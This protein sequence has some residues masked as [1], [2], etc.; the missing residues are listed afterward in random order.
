MA[1]LYCGKEIGPIR[2]LRDPEF[3]TP[4]HRKQYKDR[5]RKVLLQ[6]SSTESTPTRMASFIEASRGWSGNP[7]SVLVAAGF[8]SVHTI[9]ISRAWPV[10]IPGV[11]SQRFASL[12]PKY[13]NTADPAIRSVPAAFRWSSGLPEFTLRPAEWQPPAVEAEAVPPKLC[14]RWM[15]APKAVAAERELQPNLAPA[16][17]AS[18]SLCL[19][20]HLELA[21]AEECEPD[22]PAAA[23]PPPCVH[24]MPGL[25]ALP[26]ARMVHS[27][28]AEALP[29][30]ETRGALLPGREFFERSL[31]SAICPPEPLVPSPPAQPVVREVAA[32][33]ALL[34]VTRIEC[35]LP[36]LPAASAHS[37]C[38]NSGVDLLCPI[39]SSEPVMSEI[40]MRFCSAPLAFGTS[41]PQF[42][43]FAIQPAGETSA[44]A[45]P[46]HPG[47]APSLTPLPAE[48]PHS[49]A[50]DLF[51][52]LPVAPALHLGL[53]ESGGRL[54][55]AACAPAAFEQASGVA[56]APQPVANRNAAVLQ[57]LASLRTALPENDRP[58]PEPQI[59]ESQLIP[60][61]YHCI[62][63][64]G[65]PRPDWHW[66]TE[67]AG[68]R[69]LPFA[70]RPVFDRVETRR[71]PRTAPAPAEII[72][73]PEGGRVRRRSFVE[74]AQKAI[75][76]SVLVTIGLWCGSRAA[77]LSRMV[78]N[79]DA[80]LEVGVGRLAPGVAASGQPRTAARVT[81]AAWVRDSIA[82][83]AASEVTDSF[84]G[85]MAAWGTVG[86]SWAP[87]WSRHRDGYV[88]PG[89]LALFGPTLNYTD[90][91]LEFFGEIENKGMGWV[92]R[93]RDQQNFYA[94]KF[95]VLEPG[96][97]PVLAI[98]HYPVVGGKPG[99][100]TEVPLSIMVHN[101]TAY[102]VAVRVRGNRFTTAIEGQDV[103]SWTD[104][105]LAAGGVGFFIEAGERARLYWM[106]VSKNDDLLGRICAILSGNSVEESQTARLERAWPQRSLPERMPAPP[107][108]GG[109]DGALL[110]AE[111]NEVAFT[112]SLRAR[113]ANQKRIRLWSL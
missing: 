24:W 11:Q 64:R 2:L 105:A 25:A 86:N 47:I 10:S 84:K 92:V 38:A 52:S 12:G 14:D 78:V 55:E 111:T 85:G 48:M 97:R 17:S 36:S 82:R 42:V 72:P 35:R 66:L 6:E 60:L 29:I 80:S 87:G 104:D 59:P 67:M 57:P 8:E 83:R 99:R 34:P 109:P 1:C 113:A 61:E 50:G 7:A 56:S 16:I 106:K 3:C 62:R 79:H 101:R 23:P 88:Q 30:G 90:Y 93:A 13:R 33:A 74:H 22:A 63:G 19:P 5:L 45:A 9:R 65:V 40:S 31:R 26:A 98:V 107:R 108:P 58:Q 4:K 73:I 32:S 77:S 89:Q 81:P 43:P 70:V 37:I 103:D 102:H 71:A 100:K 49:P 28:T 96:L 41:R 112:D 75:A 46:H 94:M 68:L 54:P 27:G 91:R 51:K 39:P 15:Q 44:V 53:L 18:A 95:S 21:A 69:M 20:Q 110:A 76:A